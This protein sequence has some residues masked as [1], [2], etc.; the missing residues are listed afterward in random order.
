MPGSWPQRGHPHLNTGNCKITSPATNAYNC[1][2]WAAGNSRQWW[3]PNG[4]YYWPKGVPRE[5]SL[6]AV[7]QVYERLG[8]AICV[9]G[10]LEA[11]FEKIAIFVKEVGI[12]KIPTHAARQLE[13]GEWTSKMGPCEDISHTSVDAVGGPAYGEV[14][15]FMSRPKQTAPEHSRDQPQNT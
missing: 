15:F 5:V 6:D 9:G 2:A 7:L 14:R 12:G 11:G 4:L 10:E 1:I 3:D 8:L 13:S